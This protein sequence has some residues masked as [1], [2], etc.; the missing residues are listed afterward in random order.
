MLAI[1]DT[2]DHV[3]ITF[4]DDA[5]T[6]WNIAAEVL[7]KVFGKAPNEAQNL[8]AKI[9]K[10]GEA[11][12]GPY[13]PEVA[14]ALLKAATEYA[15]ARGHQLRLRMNRLGDDGGLGQCG[16]CLGTIAEDKK[17]Y[18]KGSGA[19]CQT[20]LAAGLSQFQGS[21]A[22]RP[23]FT[24]PFQALSW[25]FAGFP[26]EMV[27]STTRRFPGHM[28][29]DLQ[30]AI[31]RLFSAPG[32]LLF[33]VHETYRYE[34]LTLSKLMVQDNHPCMIAQVEHEE[35]DI[36]G[37]VPVKGVR[38]GLWL[39]REA[40]LPYAVLLSEHRDYGQETGMRIEIAA[41]A[42]EQG[43]DLTARYLKHLEEEVQ[44]A[45]SYRGKVLSLEPVKSYSGRAKGMTV[46]RLPPVAREDVI[47]PQ[48]TLALLDRNIVDFTRHRPQLRALGQPTRKGVLLY[49]PPGTGKT[50]TIRY[51]AS[52]LPDHTTLIITAE[53][54]A[55]LRDYMSLAR[56]LQP[57]L[58]VIEDVDLIARRRENM[59]G[60]CEESMLNE[61]LNEMDG[62][63]G[64]ADIIFV[65]TTNRPEQLEEALAGRPGRIDQAIEVPLPDEAC[66][67]RLV[68]L[69]GGNLQM[70]EGIVT[71]AAARTA[72][73]SAAFIKELMR[74]VAQATVQ[75]GGSAA[76]LADI[77]RAVEDMLFSGGQLNV[78]L[79]GG[80]V[81]A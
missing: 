46:H 11:V 19:I 27:V 52:N 61:L 81:A 78:R 23:L 39:L 63:K 12:F 3:S 21:Y 77:D 47:L 64:D 79:L 13:P 4:S 14:S 30:I 25:H 55:L 34:T 31:A 57:A 7:N 18:R 65:L 8:A 26:K 35:I 74:R 69:Y 66:R 50:H 54:V 49:G 32:S 43:A 72:G 16:F 68:R 15:A 6:P 29:A 37:D 45:R 71:A 33:G 9:S 76:T 41:P 73:M 5:A 70:D 44:G 40:K 42:G 36:G 24:F 56:L 1:P 10:S 2:A 67:A 51:L 20:C 28:R 22:E 17:V 62:L 38:N 59:N 80:R 53:Q 60:P 58:V 75:R 48:A